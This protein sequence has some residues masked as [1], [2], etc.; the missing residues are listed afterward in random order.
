MSAYLF[1]AAV[2]V[3]F[4]VH[5]LVRRERAAKWLAARRTFQ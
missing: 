1:L 2:R 3:A 4:A 5:E